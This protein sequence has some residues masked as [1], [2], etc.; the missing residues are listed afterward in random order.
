[1]LLNNVLHGLPEY[2][3]LSQHG[4]VQHALLYMAGVIRN[5]ASWPTHVCELVQANKPDYVGNYDASGFCA[6]GVW[7]GG[8][9]KLRPI[10]WRIQWPH[11]ITA[12]L[13]SDSNPKGTITNSDLEG[14]VTNS[15]L[16]MA[17]VLLQ[18]AVLETH[19]GSAMEVAHLVIGS[20]N[21]LSVARTTRMAMQSASPIAY[22]LLQGFAMRQRVMHL[23]PPT[24]YHVTG[25]MNILADVASRPVKGVTSHFHLLE[26]LPH[27]MCPDTFLTIFNSA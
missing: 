6:G 20:D 26:K 5:L 24:I 3:G 13:V 17:G 16:E 15:D 9:K 10:V 7:F 8:C 14:G 22:W 11:N 18:E 23:A 1:M 19:L 21:S 4:K 12:A 27:N 2:I 25:I